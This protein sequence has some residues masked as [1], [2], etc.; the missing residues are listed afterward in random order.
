[1]IMFWLSLVWCPCDRGARRKG[2]R[3]Q[4]APPLFSLHDYVLAVACLVPL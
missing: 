4:S 3:K 1:M 2:G